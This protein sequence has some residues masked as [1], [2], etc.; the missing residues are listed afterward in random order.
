MRDRSRA[1]QLQA[2]LPTVGRVIDDM[3]YR[4][5]RGWQSGCKRQQAAYAVPGLLRVS[6]CLPRYANDQGSRPRGD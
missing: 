1:E 6:Q 2:G 5:L 4:R 3:E